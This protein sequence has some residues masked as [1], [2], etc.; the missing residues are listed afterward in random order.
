VFALT[1]RWPVQDRD[2]RI[3]PLQKAGVSMLSNIADGKARRKRR[4]YR[5]QLG[6]AARSTA[7]LLQRLLIARQLGRPDQSRM[8]FALELA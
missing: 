1:T 5:Q 6:I 8:E 3:S 2:G 7:E 4:E